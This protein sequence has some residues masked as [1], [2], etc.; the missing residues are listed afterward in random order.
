MKM[1]LKKF[2][3][4]PPSPIS[5][6]DKIKQVEREKGFKVIR[7]DVAEPLF[8]PPKS[9]I[10]GTIDALNGGKFK[11][12]SSRGIPELRLA[13]TKF[14]KKT[15]NLDYKPDEVLIT[16]GSKFA[17]FAFFA[18]LLNH[19]DK[20]VLLKPYWTSY[21]A[22][23][24]ILGIRTIEVWSTAPYHLNEEALKKA[25]AKKPKA[26]VV[27]TPNNPTGGLLNESDIKL[28]RDLA[29]DY[30]LL[31]LSDEIDWAYVYDGDK[32]I[33]P[34]SIEGLRSR[35]VVTDGF[36]KAFGMTGWRVGFAAGPKQLIENMHI[37]QE[38]SVSAPATFAQYGCL[39]AINDSD[40]CL[41]I[42][43][44]QC[45][46]NRKIVIEAFNNS[47]HVE[48]D[49]NEGGFYVYPKLIDRRFR[50]TDEFAI[51]LLETAGVAVLPGAYFGD[52]RRHF[53][54]CYALPQA[55]VMIGVRRINNFF[56]EL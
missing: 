38:H 21:K 14:L 22:V 28:L 56:E 19:G 8:S 26:I 2:G 15:R 40:T 25:M 46:I 36:S 51:E 18:G 17:N 9:A 52:K 23:P 49:Y 45:A 31:V 54:L 44:E 35:V 37:I 7:F 5:L 27:N 16:T 39:S 42:N 47:N 24:S 33:S 55:E 6:I 32:F 4:I 53:R 29:Q 12:S 3:K 20:V 1:A 13:I 10:R 48:C 41:K 11:Y 30:D 43:I 34:A 50:S